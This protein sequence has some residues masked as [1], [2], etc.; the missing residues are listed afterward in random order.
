MMS[1]NRICRS[2]KRKGRWRR[3][4]P[5]AKAGHTTAKNLSAKSWAYVRLVC[6][7]IDL[8]IELNRYINMRWVGVGWYKYEIKQNE[9]MRSILH[10]LFYFLEFFYDP[11]AFLNCFF[12]SILKF[13]WGSPYFPCGIGG[14]TGCHW[15][16]QF[17]GGFEELL[18]GLFD[19]VDVVGNNWFFVLGSGEG[20]LGSW[21]SVGGYFWLGGANGGPLFS[22]GVGLLLRKRLFSLAIADV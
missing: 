20:G 22:S 16:S 17:F 21:D 2:L 4:A 18:H 5:V 12:D 13:C 14:L 11:N 3:T 6:W 10:I 7:V 9:R 1:K 15:L 8:M 19:V